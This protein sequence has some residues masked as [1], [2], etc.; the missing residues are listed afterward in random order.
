MFSK[1]IECG[2]IKQ[3]PAKPVKLLKEPPGRLRY[4]TPEELT[5]RVDAC[6]PHLKPIAFMAIHTGMC[7]REILSLTWSDVD[8][9]KRTITLTKTKN[10]GR[11]IIPVNN[12]LVEVL[13]TPPWYLESP[14]R[15]CVEMATLM[16]ASTMAFGGCANGRRLSISAFTT[17]GTPSP[18]T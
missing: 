15:F 7:R 16:I 18:A 14:Y 2:Y 3:N 11:R 9:G 1:A 8:L 17:S 5:R 12:T 6:A 4:L 10:N 13:R